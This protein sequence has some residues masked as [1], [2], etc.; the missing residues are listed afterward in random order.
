MAILIT[1]S[2]WSTEQSDVCSHNCGSGAQ[3]VLESAA[4][5][6]QPVDSRFP[7]KSAPDEQV[8][9]DLS[10]ITNLLREPFDA[11]LRRRHTL[12]AAVVAVNLCAMTVFCWHQTALVLLLAG[13][14]PGLTTPPDT[15]VWLLTRIAWLQPA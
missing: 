15:V 2:Y 3:A 13:P 4:D 7:Q 14:V 5:E 12:W 1:F 11:L 10:G 8:L 6:L 9:Q